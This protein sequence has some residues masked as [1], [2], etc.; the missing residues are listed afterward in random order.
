[1]APAETAM[2]RAKE[3]RVRQA[4]ETKT[5]SPRLKRTMAPQVDKPSTSRMPLQISNSIDGAPTHSKAAASAQACPQT[6]ASAQSKPVRA[7]VPAASVQASVSTASTASAAA[8][9]SIGGSGEEHRWSLE[10]F[11]IGRPLGRGKFGSVYLAR[12]KK[13]K[14][15]V[16]LKVL[17]KNQ[18][19]ESQVEHQLRREIEIQSHLRH[20][21]ILRLFGF[22]YDEKRVYLILEFAAGG[23]LYRELQKS[24]QFSEQRA[25]T[26]ILS[27]A[28]AL[29]Y[30]HSKHV[31]HR[32]IK[33]E[34]LLLGSDGEVKI[35]DFGWSVHA[36][37]S[38]RQTLCGTLD[39]LPPE[40][41]EGASH[42]RMVDVWSLGVLTYEFLYG[43]PPF[44]APNHPQTYKRIMQVDLKFPGNIKVS[45]D[46]KDLIQ[47]LL[48]KEPSARLALRDVLVHPWIQKYAQRKPREQVLTTVSG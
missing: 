48:V 37:N 46:A 32:D 29:M 44:E 26:Y 1:M 17:F 3:N 30:C 21:H 40:M 43:T 18:L 34:N 38:R 36:P 41:V 33:P 25:A 35:A 2:M 42:D 7:R 6:S 15:I 31:I 8:S 12:E 27:L 9:A 39:Y 13:S 11:D 45:S 4:V 16:A 14:F 19:Q 24:Q 20:P 23:E 22:F 10:D 47:R 5:S 28:E